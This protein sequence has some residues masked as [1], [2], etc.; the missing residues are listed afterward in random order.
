MK[1]VWLIFIL[2]APFIGSLLWFIVGK[3]AAN[4]T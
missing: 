4:A 3:R 1:L 2:V